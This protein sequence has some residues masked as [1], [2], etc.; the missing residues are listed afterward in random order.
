M[1]KDNPCQHDLM[2]IL[3]CKKCGEQ[4]HTDW[5]E[6]LKQVKLEA[7]GEVLERVQSTIKMKSKSGSDQDEA[8]KIALKAI[9]EVKD[10]YEEII[11]SKTFMEK[12]KEFP[13]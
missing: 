12:G 7:V 5:L 9:N 2:G 13:N 8:K 4:Y 1:T 3:H 10:V 6:A 11:T